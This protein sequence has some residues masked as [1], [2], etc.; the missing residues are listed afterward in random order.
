MI[1]APGVNFI[2]YTHGNIEKIPRTEL[3]CTFLGYIAAVAGNDIVDIMP[4]TAD[5]AVEVPLCIIFVGSEIISCVYVL[6][7]HSVT[8][9]NIEYWCYM[10]RIIHFFTFVNIV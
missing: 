6:I 7:I 5:P 4:G 9:K 1:C 2:G 8:F 10:Y 3:K